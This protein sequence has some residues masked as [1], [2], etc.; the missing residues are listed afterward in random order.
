MLST[1]APQTHGHRVMMEHS[2]RVQHVLRSLHDSVASAEPHVDA[3]VR[4][5]VAADP[6]LAGVQGAQRR[7]MFRAMAKTD[8]SGRTSLVQLCKNGAFKDLAASDQ[9]IV[10]DLFER[11]G[12]RLDLLRDVTSVVCCLSALA[13]S[14]RTTALA[15]LDRMADAP[16]ALRGLPKVLQCAGFRQLCAGE[17]RDVLRWYGGPELSAQAAPMR[18]N[19]LMLAWNRNRTDLVRLVEGPKVRKAE[20]AAQA[21][22]LRDFFHSRDREVLFLDATRINGHSVVIFGSAADARALSYGRR[23]VVGSH[24]RPS[25]RLYNP[26]PTVASGWRKPAGNQDVRYS[27][28]AVGISRHLEWRLLE[29]IERA[30]VLVDDLQVRSRGPVPVS[31]GQDRFVEEVARTLEQMMAGSGAVQSRSGTMMR[32]LEEKLQTPSGDVDAKLEAFLSA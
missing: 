26:D 29:H 22:L 15:Q 8:G 10:F 20:P 25:A 11:R 32:G 31:V 5:R 6:E 24:D 7:R 4:L 19:R 9:K 3:D 12:A 17:Q 2:L 14:V 30:Y 23:W 21:E 16:G 1:H 28:R 13:P 27:F 18:K